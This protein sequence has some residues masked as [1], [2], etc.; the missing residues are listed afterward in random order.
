LDDASQAADAFI[1]GLASNLRMIPELRAPVEFSAWISNV[2][3][4]HEISPTR[5]EFDVTLHVPENADA[6]KKQVYLT[7]HHGDG[8]GTPIGRANVAISTGLL[9][10]PIV[11]T[12][13]LGILA[14]LPLLAIFRWSL[15]NMEVLYFN[16][17]TL[18]RYGLVRGLGYCLLLAYYLGLGWTY[19]E[20]RKP[21]APALTEI[22]QSAPWFISLGRT[23]PV[24]KFAG[25][26]NNL[27]LRCWLPLP[28]AQRS[29]A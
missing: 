20:L 4:A 2:S 7:A 9:N 27:P 26:P 18:W 24:L 22:V 5:F 3:A 11:Q 13:L 15:P 12:V 25:R 17:S 16:L 10:D 23:G 6:G 8:F 29:I 14:A 19:N 1:A 21:D 28:T